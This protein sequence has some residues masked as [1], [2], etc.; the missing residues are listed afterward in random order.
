MPDVWRIR[1]GF[2]FP[3]KVIFF[4]TRRTT[5]RWRCA[6]NFCDST[7]PLGSKRSEVCNLSIKFPALFDERAGSL[8]ALHSELCARSFALGALQTRE[9]RVGVTRMTGFRG[10]EGGYVVVVLAICELFFT[11]R[12]FSKPEKISSLA[13]RGIF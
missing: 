3:C 6:G 1:P 8:G 11:S 2:R 13:S 12:A 10:Q 9:R 7:R 5:R 4:Y